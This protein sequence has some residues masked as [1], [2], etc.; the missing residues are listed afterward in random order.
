MHLQKII[1]L[2]QYTHLLVL[3]FLE[4]Q[5]RFFDFPKIEA[6]LKWTRIAWNQF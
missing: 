3:S 5:S 6:I 1:A 2:I 4:S